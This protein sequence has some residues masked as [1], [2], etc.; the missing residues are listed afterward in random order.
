MFQAELMDALRI[1]DRGDLTPAEMHGAW[2]GG[3]GQTQFMPSSYMKFA[4]D[5]DGNGRRE[6]P[7][8][9]M[10]APRPASRPPPAMCLSPWLLNFPGLGRMARPACA[11]RG[12]QS[13]RKL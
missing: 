1:A 12:L 5:Y 9:E 6:R 3:I 7:D 8:G 10:T 11:A 4:I 13:C 2:A